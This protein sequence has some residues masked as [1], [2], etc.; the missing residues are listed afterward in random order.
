MKSRLRKLESWLF[1]SPPPTDPILEIRPML[2]ADLVRCVIIEARSYDHAWGWAD[3]AD[4]ARDPG[5]RC[6]VAT[7]NGVVAGYC[8][9]QHRFAGRSVLIENLTVDEDKRQQGVGTALIAQAIAFAQAKRLKSVG[10]MIGEDNLACQLF[11]RE[12]G[13]RWV[14]TFRRQFGEGI[15]G[16]LFKKVIK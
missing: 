10:M 12:R 16:Y 2:A 13:F 9:Y 15:D 7:I 14:R 3:F 8:I 1:A 5:T 11:L 4:A 6:K